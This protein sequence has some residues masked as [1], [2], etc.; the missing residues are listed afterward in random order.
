MIPVRFMGFYIFTYICVA[1]FLLAVVYRIY[2]Q[3]RFPLH[4]RWE[5]YPVRHEKAARSAYGGSYMEETDWWKFPYETSSANELKYMAPEILLLRGLRKEN[6]RLWLISF[7]FH[8]GLYL[9]LATVVLLLMDTALTLWAPSLSAEGGML[10]IGLGGVTVACGWIGLVAGLAGSLGLLYRRLSDREFRLYATPADYFNIVL[11]MAFFLC[12]VLAAAFADPSFDAARAYLAGLLT[13]GTF[14]PG[15]E[16]GQSI[17]GAAT[18]LLASLLAAYIPL[19]HMSHMFMKYFLYHQ[20]KW[21]DR[22]SSPGNAIETA[23]SKNL[24]YRPNWSAKH[25]GADGDKSWKEIASSTPKD[26]K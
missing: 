20:V 21:D 10:R 22:P 24:N 9:M 15:Y 11:I 2:R 7:P 23:V 3:L 16:P 8:L 1:V 4:V 5:I 26:T 13:A 25:I 14:A 6:K 17:P 19:T 12:A 18:I